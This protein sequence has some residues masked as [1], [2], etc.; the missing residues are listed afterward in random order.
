MRPTWL[1]E[2]DVFGET[3]EPLKAEVRR[4]GMTC[5]VIRQALLA[6]NASL[7]PGGRRLADDD[8]VIF[9]GSSPCM[10]YIQQNRDWVPGGWCNPA[11]LD[12]AAYYPYFAP[13]LLNRRHAILKGVEAIA[14]RDALFAAL[15][16]EDKVFVRPSGCQKLFTGRV[17]SR[18]DFSTALAPARYDPA[19]LVVIA[20]PRPITREW[21]LVVAEGSV[22]AASQYLAHGAIDVAP[23]CPDAVRTFAGDVLAAVKWRPDEMF[24]MDLCESEVSLFLLELNSFSCSAL[25]QCDLPIVVATA[26][27]LAVRS[28]EKRRSPT[29]DQITPE[30]DPI[31]PCDTPSSAPPSSS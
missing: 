21:R 4:Q 29:V 25:Y 16:R 5:A 23:G 27:E 3:A 28:W 13:F 14:Q 30:S 20:E 10:L 17:V 15:S 1:F 7:L 19:T 12:C 8:C 26:N 18:D 2:A 11:A 6:S 31:S 9:C 22:I 24:M